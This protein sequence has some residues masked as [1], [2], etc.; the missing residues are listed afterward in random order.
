MHLKTLKKLNKLKGNSK[1]GIWH[2]LNP[3]VHLIT[4]NDDMILNEV[5]QRSVGVSGKLRP[6]LHGVCLK[7]WVKSTCG[8]T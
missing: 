4:T 5:L 6:K 7:R 1:L 3:L 2:F 8:V